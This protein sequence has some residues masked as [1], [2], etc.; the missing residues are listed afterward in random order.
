MTETA[1]F[2]SSQES[3]LMYH[4]YSKP[5]AIK[6]KLN[7]SIWV[8]TMN[9]KERYRWQKPEGGFHFCNKKNS[10]TLWHKTVGG[11]TFKGQLL[12][13]QFLRKLLHINNRKYNHYSVKVEP[14]LR[15]WYPLNSVRPVSCEWYI[16]DRVLS[17]AALFLDLLSRVWFRGNCPVAVGVFFVWGSEKQ[18]NYPP[19]TQ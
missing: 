1:T 7:F 10:S 15:P 18:P 12:R 13:K 4:Y 6:Q 3:L 16:T 5:H 11:R 14:G 2:S 19:P 8:T 17:A 9:R